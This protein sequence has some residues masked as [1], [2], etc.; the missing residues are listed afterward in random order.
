MASLKDRARKAKTIFTLDTPTTTFLSPSWPSLP[1][2]T[3][4][5]LL[6]TLLTILHPPSQSST[7]IETHDTDS[8]PTYI[9]NINAVTAH[10]EHL[11]TTSTK[12][13]HRALAIFA[14]RND[15]P[16]AITSHLP[17]LCAISD[18][19]LLQLPK[20][21]SDRLSRVLQ[22]RRIYALAIL[23]GT[24]AAD[25]L[26]PYLAADDGTPLGIV[27]PPD[28]LAD[29]GKKWLATRSSAVQTFIGPPKQKKR[30]PSA[31][32]EPSKKRKT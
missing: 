10:L 6:T 25:T 27:H 15:H 1:P 12:T 26:R 8:K 16:A 17:L 31:T 5:T 22:R 2:T 3:A 7:D 19:P 20:G 23:D 32:D 21:A 13:A 11:T 30:Q 18:T 4:A 9:A 29:G 28:A 14:T 24:P